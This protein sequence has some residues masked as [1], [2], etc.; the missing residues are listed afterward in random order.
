M[1]AKVVRAGDT[2][3]P[4]LTGCN[5]IKCERIAGFLTVALGI[6]VVFATL[7]T[8]VPN[9][10]LDYL[11][12]NLILL[13]LQHES[14]SKTQKFLDLEGFLTLKSTPA[15]ARRLQYPR[16]TPVLHAS[17]SDAR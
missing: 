4:F 15:L 13:D 7:I 10:Q 5:Q 14:K 1:C 6:P 3:E 9:G 8:C 2:A 16:R 11:I 17:V 12:A